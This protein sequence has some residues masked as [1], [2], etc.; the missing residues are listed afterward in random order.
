MTRRKKTRG[1]RRKAKAAEQARVRAWLTPKS[2]PLPPGTRLEDIQFKY[3]SGIMVIDEKA[4]VRS[5]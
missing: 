4:L 5:V 2:F 1:K 3:T